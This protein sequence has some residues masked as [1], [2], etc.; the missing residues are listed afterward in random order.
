MYEGHSQEEAI[1]AAD[2]KRVLDSAPKG[3]PRLSGG[4]IDKFD[5]SGLKIECIGV[6]ARRR[7]IGIDRTGPS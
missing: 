1:L 2:D 7:H 6:R 3:T 4:A 5:P